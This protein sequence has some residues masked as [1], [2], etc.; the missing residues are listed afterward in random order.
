MLHLPGKGKQGVSKF[1]LTML[2]KER[3]WGQKP[4]LSL[5][6]IYS[7]A[8]VTLKF[9]T[10]NLMNLLTF[11]KVLQNFDGLYELIVFSIFVFW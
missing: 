6:K 2:Q 1:W 3:L 7:R 8:R 4:D 11:V 5:E 10:S 9:S